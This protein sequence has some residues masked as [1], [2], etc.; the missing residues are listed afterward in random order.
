MAERRSVRKQVAEPLL[1]LDTMS[2]AQLGRIGNLSTDGL[3]L[4]SAQPIPEQHVYE[5]LFPL[6]GTWVGAQ[7]LEVG[8]QCL[9]SEP[10]STSDSHWAGCHIISISPEH[11]D[12]LEAWVETVAE[13]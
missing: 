5:V 8:I 11:Q 7:R 3:M 4:I 10:A 1:V 2:G 6:P 13:N 12:L 9:W